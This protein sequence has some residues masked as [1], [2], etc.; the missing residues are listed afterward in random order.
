MSV[1][2]SSVAGLLDAATRALYDAGS[3]TPR[4]DAELL[5]AHVLGGRRTHLLAHPEALVDAQPAARFGDLVARRAA[6]EP[7][8]YLRGRQEFLGIPFVC[9]P[10]ALVPRPETERL[11]ELAE[12]ELVEAA[13]AV[14]GPMAVADVG[15]GSGAIAV[16]LAVR[17]RERDRDPGVTV[18]A[19]D[20]SADAL[21][22]AAENVAAQ[23]VGGI[24]RLELGDLLPSGLG[25]FRL[26][27]ANLPY[28]RTA[29]LAP[30]PD[31]TAHEPR[32]ALDGGP[33]GLR[34]IDRLLERL[35]GALA[36]DGL[37]LFEIGA[38]QGESFPALAAERLPGWGCEILPDLAGHPR[39]ARLTPPERVAGAR[40]WR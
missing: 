1:E 38:D 32:L 25:P 21:A 4:L 9:D 40:K 29:D 20:A 30:A 6:G 5:L 15:T 33:D 23:A 18:H 36:P 22:L 14:H 26:V 31:P 10:R 2:P 17:L 11:V 13:A 34:V 3:G 28:V 7:V 37:A 12:A 24:V 35:P 8:A 19:I 27:V 16:A 39:I